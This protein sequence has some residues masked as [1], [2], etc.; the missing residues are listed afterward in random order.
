MSKTHSVVV[1]KVKRG[2]GHPLGYGYVGRVQPV[3]SSHQFSKLHKQYTKQ[4][5]YE[6]C[7]QEGQ[8]LATQ[9]VYKKKE[10]HTHSKTS[11][12]KHTSTSTSKST[13]T[14]SS[15]K[16]STVKANSKEKGWVSVFINV[17][18]VLMFI[19]GI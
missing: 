13:T 17:I 6:M 5:E 7:F 14:S 3:N 12:E 16:Y 4:P 11:Q 19:I 8:T 10:K 1:P 2:R 9:R 18:G 15:R